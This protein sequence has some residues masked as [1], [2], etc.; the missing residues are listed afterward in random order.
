[1]RFSSLPW[2]LLLAALTSVVVTTWDSGAVLAQSEASPPEDATARAAF[3]LGRARFNEGH[4]EEALT[5]F[6]DAHQRSQRP[7]LVY[8]IAQTL[9]R[10]SRAV[11]ARDAYRRYLEEEPTAPQR[12]AIEA[13]IAVLE[14]E[15]AAEE[16]RRRVLAE[17]ERALAEE[18]ARPPEGNEIYEEWWFWTIIGVAVVGGAVGVGVGVGVVRNRQAPLPGDD[19]LVIT[20]L[21]SQPG[22]EVSF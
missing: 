4:F 19:G 5:L 2:L 20:T 7:A 15:L 12:A 6:E 11:E 3:E 16:E 17:T 10:L 21:S 8:N 1:M 22:L 9:D 18:R 14:Q 13:R